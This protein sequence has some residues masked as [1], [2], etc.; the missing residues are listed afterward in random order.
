MSP[1]GTLL[2]LLYQ[3]S[4]KYAFCER[5]PNQQVVLESVQQAIFSTFRAPYYAIDL[6]VSVTDG[7]ANFNLW[8]STP[9]E[10]LFRLV[11]AM[12]Q[13][14]GALIYALKNG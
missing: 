3:L 8:Q 12:T 1:I 7:F 10:V 9:N 5:S 6:E 2:V 4:C 14:S 13:L 11:A